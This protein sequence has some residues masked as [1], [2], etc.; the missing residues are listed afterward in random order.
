MKESMERSATL[1]PLDRALEMPFEALEK[2]AN[3]IRDRINRFRVGLG[4]HFVAKQP[5]IDLMTVSAVAQEPLL[6]VGP[7]GTA[8]SDLVLI[9]SRLRDE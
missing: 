2:E 5:L 4:R 3:T 8:K 6:L 7:P 9:G 1:D